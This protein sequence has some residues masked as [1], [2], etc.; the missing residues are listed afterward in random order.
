MKAMKVCSVANNVGG[1]TGKL[2]PDPASGT[3][4]RNEND[5][6]QKR[7]EWNLKLQQNGTEMSNAQKYALGNR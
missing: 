6:E 7:P 1:S 5:S 3:G 4:N 2:E